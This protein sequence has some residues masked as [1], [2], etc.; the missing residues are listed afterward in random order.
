[1]WLKPGERGQGPQTLAE[2]AGVYRE[3][4]V[5]EPHDDGPGVPEAPPFRAGEAALDL[6]RPRQCER[7]GSGVRK[8]PAQSIGRIGLEFAQRETGDAAQAVPRIDIDRDPGRQHRGV[9]DLP[10]P[11]LIARHVPAEKP[12]RAGG[13]R[14]PRKP[15]RQARRPRIDRGERQTGDRD[16]HLDGDARGGRPDRG[17]PRV[18]R[19]RGGFEGGMDFLEVHGR[20]MDF[21]RGGGNRRRH[22]LRNGRVVARRDRAR[23]AEVRMFSRGVDGR[24][25]CDR[26]LPG[27]PVAAGRGG[28]GER[29]SSGVRLRIGLFVAH[30]VSPLSGSRPGV[31]SSFVAPFGWRP[32]SRRRIW[33]VAKPA[34]EDDHA[35]PALSR[36]C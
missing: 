16:E 31:P 14:L 36:K 28:S 2:H 34:K 7:R 35:G 5:L 21:G 6:E 8:V 27:M 18:R 4:L 1:M 17:E 22:V 23:C 15:L 13:D 19:Q 26:H 12:G 20:D 24:S 9:E 29:R 32:G 33:S 3:R 30:A 25:R 11:R 10:P